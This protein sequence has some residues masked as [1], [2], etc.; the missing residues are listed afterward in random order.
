MK[1]ILLIIRNAFYFLKN[2]KF[3]MGVVL[4]YPNNCLLNKINFQLE[5]ITLV[6]LNYT[7]EDV[8]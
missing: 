4:M 6:I 7:S 5:Q 3:C 2:S 8:N 1:N